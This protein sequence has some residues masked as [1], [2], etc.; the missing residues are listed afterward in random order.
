LSLLSLSDLLKDKRFQTISFFL[1]FLLLFVFGSFRFDTGWD[2]ATYRFYFDKIP[3]ISIFLNNGFSPDVYFEFGFKLL[4]SIIKTLN[5]S[6]QFLIF[7]SNLFVL[8]C[9][10]NFIDEEVKHKNLA[11]LLFYST[12]YLFLNFSILRQGI[13]IG[14]LLLSLRFL[15]NKKIIASLMMIF[16][17]SLFHMTAI[18]FLPILLIANYTYLPRHLYLILF[19]SVTMFAFLPISLVEISLHLFQGILPNT[20]V[21]KLQHYMGNN[22]YGSQRTLGLGFVEKFGFIT[23]FI[24]HAYYLRSDMKPT[25]RISTI[26][27]LFLAY[28]SI[29]ILFIDIQVIYT[30]MKFY[31]MTISSFTYSYLLIEL[32]RKN[33]FRTLSAILIILFSFVNLHNTLRYKPNNVVFI[34]YQSIIS[35]PDFLN[36]DYYRILRASELIGP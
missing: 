27:Y 15:F 20:I 13:A 11:V 6:F 24:F 26:G 9:V 22:Y 10:Y 18:V 34:P 17:A 12:C 5:L 8:F 23:L 1:S 2:F 7:L 4:I 3:T 35:E 36:T 30:R 14:I 28:Y 21:S 16:L 19:S 32:F 33:S 31:F 29:Y 25:K